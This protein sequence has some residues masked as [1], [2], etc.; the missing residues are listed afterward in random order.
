[1]PADAMSLLSLV[2]AITAAGTP[3]PRMSRHVTN[4]TVAKRRLPRFCE[5]STDPMPPGPPLIATKRTPRPSRMKARTKTSVVIRGGEIYPLGGGDAALPTG[6]GS[7][8][9]PPWEAVDA[10][11]VPAGTEPEALDGCGGAG[12]HPATSPPVAG[13]RPHDP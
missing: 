11:C 6:G 10:A 8:P 5:C 9:G 2:A 1:M 13:E 7:A 4:A 12:T 3:T